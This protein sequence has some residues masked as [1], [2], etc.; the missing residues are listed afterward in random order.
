MNLELSCL[1]I[2][3]QDEAQTRLGDYLASLDCAKSPTGCDPS[4]T[5]RISAVGSKWDPRARQPLTK[6]IL[7]D[8][9][10][11]MVNPSAITLESGRFR[12][13]WPR[14]LPLGEILQ[15]QIQAE[16]LESIG[17]WALIDEVRTIRTIFVDPPP[18]K[19]RSDLTEHH[20]PQKRDLP[21]DPDASRR[22]FTPLQERVIT[23]LVKKQAGQAA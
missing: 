12:L 19:P 20:A 17:L 4:L 21:T 10:Q 8:A 18:V 23:P 15:L 1:F 7:S 6:E 16:T 5:V 11:L 9:T 2:R 22:L 3:D 14:S 13:M